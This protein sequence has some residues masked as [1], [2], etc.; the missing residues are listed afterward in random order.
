MEEISADRGLNMRPEN[1]SV[2]EGQK[3]VINRLS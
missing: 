1:I 2:S 3:E